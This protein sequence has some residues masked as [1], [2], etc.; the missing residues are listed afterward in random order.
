MSDALVAES[1]VDVWNDT[2]RQHHRPEESIKVFIPADREY[3][4]AWGNPRL[5]VVLSCVGGE[6][7]NLSEDEL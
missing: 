3:E 5:L 7:E 4:M 2:T 1:V 6:F